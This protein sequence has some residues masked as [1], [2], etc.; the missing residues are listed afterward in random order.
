MSNSEIQE[1][2]NQIK[3]LENELSIHRQLDEI[4]NRLSII[5]NNLNIS[6][7][8][9][10]N[11]QKNEKRKLF[12]NYLKK[13]TN[14]E[15]KTVIDELKNGKSFNDISILLK[16]TKG[17]VSAKVEKMIVNMYNDNKDIDNIANNLFINKLYVK[18]TLEKK[19]LLIE[20]KIEN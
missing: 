15:E 6:K 7:K 10:Y 2:K 12:P 4:K 13:W 20:Q 3:K 14:D 18:Q 17:A 19:N 11:L 1:L 8:E 5:E 9:K 16:R